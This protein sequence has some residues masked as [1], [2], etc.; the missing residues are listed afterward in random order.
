MSFK[1][2]GFGDRLASASRAKTAAVE[3]FR[4]KPAADDP[5][6]L[7]RQAEQAAIKAARSPRC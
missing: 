7:K 2:P 5:V 1:D 4:T 6:V 3:K